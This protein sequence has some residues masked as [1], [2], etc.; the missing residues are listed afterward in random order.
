[1]FCIGAAPTLPGIRDR[2]SIP[3]YPLFKDQRTNSCQ[4]SPACTLINPSP[5]TSIPLRA[6]FTTKPLKSLQSK[7]LLPPPKINF[8]KLVKRASA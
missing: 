7:R 3:L 6:T 2:F 8:G 1:M 5:T 4:F